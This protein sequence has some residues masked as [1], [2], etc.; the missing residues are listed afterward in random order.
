MPVLPTNALSGTSNPDNLS[1]GINEGDGVETEEG[2]IGA[3]KTLSLNGS[4]NQSQSL[5]IFDL[6]G[7][8]SESDSHMTQNATTNHSD[9][10]TNLLDLLDVFAPSEMTVSSNTQN[11]T[12]FSSDLFGTKNG[13]GAPII[14]P[15]P[16]PSVLDFNFVN[17]SGP[18]P[19]VPSITIY[20]SNEIRIV[21]NFVPSAVLDGHFNIIT[22]QL[23]ATTTSL[24]PIDSFEFQAAV[25][26]SCQLQLFPPSSSSIPCGPN[27]TPLTQVLKLSVPPKV[28]W[29]ALYPFS[30]FRKLLYFL[31]FASYFS[32]M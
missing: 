26:K 23:V 21:F 32:E 3:A 4:T 13:F 22:I 31:A 20:N 18:V 17:D 9:T 10:G 11:A 25:P 16:Q 28:N 30:F 7:P 1:R 19:S 15:A 6:L 14:Q 5:T 24:Q 12:G 8:E 27:S 29:V 2:N